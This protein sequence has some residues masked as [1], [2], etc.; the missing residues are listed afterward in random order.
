VAYNSVFSYSL[1]GEAFVQ[2]VTLENPTSVFIAMLVF[3]PS[4]ELP[5]YKSA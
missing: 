3:R 5:L 2:E 1:I 4:F